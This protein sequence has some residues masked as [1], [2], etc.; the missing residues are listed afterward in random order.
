MNRFGAAGE[1][2]TDLTHT[3]TDGD[4]VIKGLSLEFLPVFGALPTGINPQFLQYPKRI[5]MDAAW[6]TA[7]TENRDLALC[8]MAQDA[9]RHL[10]AGAVFRA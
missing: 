5:G 1:C 6:R 7:R 4:D 2:R 8:Q 3:V 10:R 9:L